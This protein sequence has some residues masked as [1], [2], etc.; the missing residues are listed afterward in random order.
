[1]DFELMP[2]RVE[3]K[4]LSPY[5]KNLDGAPLAI[6]GSST[7]GP[8]RKNFSKA[9]LI[10]LRYRGKRLPGRAKKALRRDSNKWM[11]VRVC[12]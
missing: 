2:V 12:P 1:M 11:G 6:V 9:Y 10:R 4:D 3:V 8:S 5:I 7:R